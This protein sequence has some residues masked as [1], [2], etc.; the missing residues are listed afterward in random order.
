MAMAKR[1]TNAAKSARQ[2]LTVPKGRQKKAKHG[3]VQSQCSATTGHAWPMHANCL[4]KLACWVLMLRYVRERTK[5]K[6]EHEHEDKD[7][8]ALV[9]TLLL[10]STS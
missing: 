4:L 9:R 10:R 6:N 3:T 1:T 8:Y 5:H 7:V 2:A